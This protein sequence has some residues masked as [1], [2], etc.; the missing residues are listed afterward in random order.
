MALTGSV[1]DSP[2]EARYRSVGINSVGAYQ[3]S[4]TPFLTGASFNQ[5]DDNIDGFRINFPTM[6]KSVTIINKSSTVP[7]VVH[8]ASRKETNNIMQQ[9]RY[10]TLSGEDT[11][12]T[13]AVKCR[14]VWISSAASGSNTGSFEM[15]AE[16]TPIRSS[17]N[18]SGSVGITKRSDGVE[19]G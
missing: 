13:F 8:F 2:V 9:G 3:V 7:L 10:I 17:F 15:L 4:G 6:T 1:G 11:S 5:T 18:L 16:L 12:M 19:G 14:Q